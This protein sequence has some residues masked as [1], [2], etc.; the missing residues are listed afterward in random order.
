M[1][2]SGNKHFTILYG[3]LDLLGR[4]LQYVSAGH[5][6]LIHLR[7]GASPE[8]IAVEGMAIGWCPEGEFDERTIQL[9]SGDRV[10]IYSDGVPEAMSPE[11]KKFG[12]DRLLESLA[13]G[14]ASSLGD[15][16]SLVLERVEKWCT[17]TG[18]KDDVSLFGIEMT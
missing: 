6:P 17:P 11:M 4:E 5:P 14:G 13:A 16:L 3:V 1:E 12:D 9:E 2:A 7:A 18:P 15:A 10:C 8:A